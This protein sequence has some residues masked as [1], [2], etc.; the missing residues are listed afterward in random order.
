MTRLRHWRQKFDPN[1]R[2]V[3]RRTVVFLDRQYE[4]GDLV[5]A[6]AKEMG[7]KLMNMWNAHFIERA[8]EETVE[9][10]PN[11]EVKVTTEQAKAE[12][13]PKKK[14]G[15]PSKAELAARAEAEAKAKAEAEAK[16]EDAPPSE[17]SDQPPVEDGDS[18]EGVTDGDG[19]ES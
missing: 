19:A 12:E 17:D 3:F 13:P 1:A 10:D 6:E 18:S 9:S 5:P 4:P 8:P 14:R 11:E 7:A 16:E 2:H 15:R